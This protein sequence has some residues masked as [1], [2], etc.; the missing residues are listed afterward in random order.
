NSTSPRACVAVGIPARI[1]ACGRSRACRKFGGFYP[2]CTYLSAHAPATSPKPAPGPAPRP[3]LGAGAEGP[4]HPARGARGAVAERARGA[5]SLR[6]ARH[7][8]RAGAG[9]AAVERALLCDRD[10]DD[11]P[12]P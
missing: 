11:R 7:R 10:G 4:A 9:G 2:T 12:A 1:L 8:G 5:V 6:R 3:G